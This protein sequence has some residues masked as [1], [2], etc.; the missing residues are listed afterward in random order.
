[1]PTARQKLVTMTAQQPTANV[2]DEPLEE[3]RALESIIGRDGCEELLRETMNEFFGPEA[4]LDGASAIDAASRESVCKSQQG[5]N[6]N[7][8][9]GQSSLHAIP[10]MMRATGTAFLLLITWVGC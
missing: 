2:G 6:G 1:M 7:G 8:S 4:F 5:T 3:L 9:N 10:D